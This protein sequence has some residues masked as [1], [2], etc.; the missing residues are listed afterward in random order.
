[1]S[2]ARNVRMMRY[3]PIRLI[4]L[5]LTGLAIASVSS[6]SMGEGKKACAAEARRL[7]PAEMRAVSRKRV[8]ACKIARIDQTS[9][10]CHTAMLQIKAQ[11]EAGI[12][13]Q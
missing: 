2:I 8:E 5:Q 6:P 3:P 1:M 11:R 7:C 12:K 13:R 9:A 4:V 10:L